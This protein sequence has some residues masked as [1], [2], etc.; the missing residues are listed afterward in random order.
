MTSARKTTGWVALLLA[1]SL[2]ICGCNSDAGATA[3]A[4][5][6]APT[7]PTAGAKLFSDPFDDDHNGWALPEN[8]NSRMPFE[9]GDFLW[10]A[11]RPG[12]DLRPHLTA[13]PLAD[14]FDH[15]TLHMRNVVVRTGFTPVRGSG[16]MGVFCREVRDTDSDFQWY[17]FVARDGYAAIRHA[18]SAGHLDVLA[19]TSKLDMPLGEKATIEAAC[20]DDAKGRGQL[21]LSVNGK[22]TLYT[23]DAHPLGNGVPGLQAY[24]SPSK[25]AKDRYL[26]RWHDFAVYR[27]TS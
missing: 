14:A 24:D 1:A 6:S 12:V 21:W 7:A 25:E 10:E 26:I 13:T 11:K 5:R 2:G 4:V 8:E 27:P 22:P 15:G 3:D 16:A 9:D 17:E 20:V 19:K 18:D 23:S